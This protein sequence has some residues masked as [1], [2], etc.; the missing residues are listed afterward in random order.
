M[1]KTYT[2]ST[3]VA[4]LVPIHRESSTEDFFN[5]P[6]LFLISE[7]M[8]L[9]FGWRLLGWGLKQRDWKVKLAS[10]GRNGEQETRKYKEA[11][12]LSSP[13]YFYIYQNII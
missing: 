11:L 13:T 12:Y 9:L 1:L 8:I 10:T 5:I 4:Q 6:K 7:F 3:E 2:E